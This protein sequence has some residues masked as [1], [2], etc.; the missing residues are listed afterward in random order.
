MIDY[1]YQ[2]LF[3]LDYC[4]KDNGFLLQATV[5]ERKSRE[6][7]L[8]KTREGERRKHK[9]AKA[10]QSK[11]LKEQYIKRNKTEEQKHNLKK[12]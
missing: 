12:W 3:V 2:L 7:K 8:M 11:D 6:K 10:K 4:Y 5:C 1:H 9:K